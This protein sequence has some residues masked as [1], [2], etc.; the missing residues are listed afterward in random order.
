MKL[1]R[2]RAF[3]NLKSRTQTHIH[4][5]VYLMSVCVRKTKTKTRLRIITNTQ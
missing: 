5:E 3:P 1:V 4:R 2:S